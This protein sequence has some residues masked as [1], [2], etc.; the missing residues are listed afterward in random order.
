V[1]RLLR[2]FSRAP[3]N[4]CLKV[5]VIVVPIMGRAR[6]LEGTAPW[7]AMVRGLVS[8]VR[9]SR[10]HEEKAAAHAGGFVFG[11]AYGG[12]IIVREPSSAAWDGGQVFLMSGS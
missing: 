3:G 8:L 9:R 5:F 6:L 1:G 2:T 4:L 11:L 7:R 12:G 10:V